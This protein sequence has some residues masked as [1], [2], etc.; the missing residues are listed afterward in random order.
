M[1]TVNA[2]CCFPLTDLLQY[3][4]PGEGSGRMLL[5]EREGYYAGESL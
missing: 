4:D 5:Q 2:S 1:G 3:Y